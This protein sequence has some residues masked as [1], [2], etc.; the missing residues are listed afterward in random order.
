MTCRAQTPPLHN[1]KCRA[2][3][4]DQIVTRTETS[5]PEA[6]LAE[7]NHEYGLCAQP[8]AIPHRPLPIALCGKACEAQ[9]RFRV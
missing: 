4:P 6:T 5:S 3:V 1:A 9:G 2:A 8:P 7:L